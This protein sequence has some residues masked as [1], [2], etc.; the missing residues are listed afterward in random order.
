MHVAYQH[1]PFLA[2]SKTESIFKKVKYKLI[3]TLKIEMT[4]NNKTNRFLRKSVILHAKHSLIL[5]AA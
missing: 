3:L 1:H 4:S 5:I 2:M